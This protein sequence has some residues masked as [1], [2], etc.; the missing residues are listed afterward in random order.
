MTDRPAQPSDGRAHQGAR[1][2]TGDLYLVVGYDGSAPADE[3][4]HGAV[5]DNLFWR[6]YRPVTP[7]AGGEAARL[8]RI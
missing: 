6:Q 2:A 7:L 4:L 3:R 1:A 8:R 5:E